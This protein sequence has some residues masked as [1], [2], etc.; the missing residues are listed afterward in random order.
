MLLF[1]NKYYCWAPPITTPSLLLHK[2]EDFHFFGRFV[3]T[4]RWPARS[5]GLLLSPGGHQATFWKCAT[6]VTFGAHCPSQTVIHMVFTKSDF[7]AKKKTYIFYSKHICFYTNPCR[8]P[9][10]FESC[11]FFSKT[12]ILLK[13]QA[14]FFKGLLPAGPATLQ[15]PSVF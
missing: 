10:W 2:S 12:L 14:C 4:K 11:A 6:V 3:L 1:L 13:R 15:K 9:L 8:R 7:L 5:K